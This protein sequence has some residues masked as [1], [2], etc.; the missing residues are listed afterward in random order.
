MKHTYRFLI[1]GILLMNY[2]IAFCQLFGGQIKPVKDLEYWFDNTL[3]GGSKY[4][5]FKNNSNTDIVFSKLRL[6]HSIF[7]FPYR[8]GPFVLS[9]TGVN[10]SY[11]GGG[12]IYN[13]IAY[14][15]YQLDN[16][17]IPAFQTMKIKVD[18]DV[19]GFLDPV[20]SSNASNP[21]L[22]N[23]KWIV[24]D[25]NNNSIPGRKGNLFVTFYTDSATN[26]NDSL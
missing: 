10:D 21:Y 8:T 6:Y 13:G 24:T 14:A 4:F 16:Y 3:S 15:L 1:I 26:P 12:A 17:T 25:S 2:Q 23:I 9:G 18:I 5:Y 22:H 7:E 20:W 19:W 11:G